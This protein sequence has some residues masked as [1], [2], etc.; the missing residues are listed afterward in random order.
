M[1]IVS[2]S[3][4]S[5]IRGSNKHLELLG[6]IIE[7][8]SP[9]ISTKAIFLHFLKV[10]NCFHRQTGVAYLEMPDNS[11]EQHRPNMLADDHNWQDKILTSAIKIKPSSHPNDF[12]IQSLCSNRKTTMIRAIIPNPPARPGVRSDSLS[13]GTPQA[14]R[15][16]FVEARY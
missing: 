8:Y 7:R 16:A 4:N 2:R 15:V 11:K 10:S 5:G 1:Q 9:D 6:D 13:S 3:D 12:L 14:A